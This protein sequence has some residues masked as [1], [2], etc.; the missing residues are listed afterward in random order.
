MSQRV[1]RTVLA[2]LAAG[3]A[4]IGLAAC[5]GVTGEVASSQPTGTNALPT[6]TTPVATETTEAPSEEPS[7][8]P[9]DTT[10]AFGKT[11]TWENGVSATVSAP[12]SYRSSGNGIGGEKFKYAVIFTVT[13]V[14]KSGKAYDP[15]IASATV[16]SADAEGDQIFDSSNDLGGTPDTKVLNGRQTKFKM[17]FGVA[18]PKDV[19]VEFSPGFEYNSAIWTK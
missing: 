6:A 7:E 10:V 17:A 9:D 1:K 4:V 8:T 5:G 2:A 15:S 18:N 13:I 14:N 12:K 19:V 3:T 11:F 16:Q